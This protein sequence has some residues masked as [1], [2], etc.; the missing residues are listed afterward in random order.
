MACALLFAWSLASA[1]TG[2]RMGIT[3]N[4]TDR[5]AANDLVG[6][7]AILGDQLESQPDSSQADL[8]EARMRVA[9][10]VAAKR[11]LVGGRHRNHSV[12][13]VHLHN[14]GGTYLC[15]EARKQGESTSSLNCNV[16]PDLCSASPQQR[17]SCSTR[18]SDYSFSAIE[19]EL[20]DMDLACDGTLYGLALRDPLAAARSTMAA[21]RFSS[22]DRQSIRRAIESQASETIPQQGPHPCLPSWDTYHHFDNFATRSLSGHYDLAAGT[23][24]REHLDMAKSQ[25]LRMHVVLILE[26]L[27]DHLAQLQASFGWDMSLMTPDTEQNSH[28][29]RAFGDVLTKEEETFFR[30]ANKFDYELLEFGRLVAANLTKAAKR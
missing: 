7:S 29:V 1:A 23:V 9:D 15:E 10:A 30:N 18:R 2:M 8:L 26:E 19:R 5:T 21:N 6:I 28:P 11:R 25:L 13:W 3:R 20:T 12:L 22:M 16:R 14:F 17:V 4:G 24:E 27:N